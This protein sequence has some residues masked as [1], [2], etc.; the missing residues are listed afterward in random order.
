MSNIEKQMIFSTILS[1]GMLS[2][3][4]ANLQIMAS[5]F[6]ALCLETAQ[7]GL[8]FHILWTVNHEQWDYMHVLPLYDSLAS[9]ILY[10][11]CSAP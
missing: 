2:V 4:K 11:L 3:I 9:Y 7:A 10:I 1:S 6:F 5:A 8:Q